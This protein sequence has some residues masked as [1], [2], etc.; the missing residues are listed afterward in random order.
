MNKTE[1]LK[2]VFDEWKAKHFPND[3][4]YRD[5]I[6]NEDEFQAS[7]LGKRI[8]FIAKEPNAGKHGEALID[9]SFIE[10]WNNG[11]PQYVFAKRIAEWSYGILNGFPAYNQAANQVGY[12]KKIAFI[13]LKKLGGTG[14]ANSSGIL[15]S[16]EEH[17]ELLRMQIDIISPNIIIMCT[18]FDR[19]I[20]S[21]LFN[22]VKWVDSG[23]QVM[24][25]K[26]N[27]ISII[28]FYHPSSRNVPAAS[29]SLLQNVIASTPFKGFLG[30]FEKEILQ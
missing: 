13:N 26:V 27:Q 2:E 16:V 22:E 21:A 15:K 5:G 18:S 6:I 30:P 3:R 17:S 14:S 19:K 28:D 25:A 8:L 4:L 20:C 24:I 1:E 23:Y 29:Y 12:L 9:P 10:E 7:P 11:N